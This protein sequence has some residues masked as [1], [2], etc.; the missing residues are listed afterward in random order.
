MFVC[1]ENN[2]PLLDPLD[3]L[4]YSW[5]SGIFFDLS[6]LNT[7]KCNLRTIVHLC[8]W[9]LFSLLQFR[10]HLFKC[11][12]KTFKIICFYAL[13][14]WCIITIDTLVIIL[15]NRS[16]NLDIF[17]SIT[18]LLPSPD[19]FNNFFPKVVIQLILLDKIDNRHYYTQ[20]K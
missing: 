13:T 10:P 14:K 16:N 17:I 11:S 18:H 12:W 3:D 1:I 7:I 19:F 2:Y 9:W 15:L 5:I 6:N 8:H 20:S 4:E